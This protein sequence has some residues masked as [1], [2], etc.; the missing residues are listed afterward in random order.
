LPTLPPQGGLDEGEQGQGGSMGEK[1]GGWLGRASWLPWPA[2]LIA[3]VVGWPLLRSGW[4]RRRIHR[5]PLEERLQA[6]LALLRAELSD[7]R[8]PVAPAD[9]LEET[10]EV[11]HRHLG[12]DPDPAFVDRVDAV[13]FGGRMATPGDV[14]QSE[15]L[16]REVKTRLRKR[17]GWTRTIMAWYGLSGRGGRSELQYRDDKT[18]P[19]TEEVARIHPRTL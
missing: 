17:H 2:A 15:K 1:G 8:A 12:F 18:G 9:T 10:S 3:V 14:E 4:R 7:Y 19:K 5:G 13:L 6:S 11:L 16:R